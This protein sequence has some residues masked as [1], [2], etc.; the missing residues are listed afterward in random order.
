MKQTRNTPQRSLILGLM[1]NNYNHPTADEVYELA[2][3]Q[4]PH[5]S[6]ATVYRNLNLLAEMGE[7]RRLSMPDGPD[8]FDCR[9][10]NHYHFLCRSCKKVVDTILPYNEMLNFAEAGLPGYRTEWH[11]LVLVG[12]C[13]KCSG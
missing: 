5:I 4:E 6:R 11:R 1:E 3:K 12:F 10:T 7:I 2:R 8:H 9:M 13:P